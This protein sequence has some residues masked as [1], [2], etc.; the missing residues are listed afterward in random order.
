MSKKDDLISEVQKIISQYS[1]M[2]LTLRQIYYRLVTKL[3]IENKISNYKYLSKVL[4][5]ARRNGQIR[6]DSIEDRTR[7]VNTNQRYFSTAREH[8]EY[9]IDSL[10]ECNTYYTVPKLHLQKD[11]VIVV[12]EKQA[13]QAIFDPVCR[14]NEAYL[15]VCRG[16]NSLTQLKELA[17]ELKEE[18]KK[19]H[20]KF[21]SDFDPTGLDIQRNFRQQMNDFDIVFD[22]FKRIGLTQELIDK[23]NL[24]FAPVKTSDSRAS[25]WNALGVVELDALEPVDLQNLILNSILEHF[26]EDIYEENRRVYDKNAFELNEMFDKIREPLEIIKSKILGWD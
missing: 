9:H 1:G 16:Y 17:D 10:F 11:V 23:Y 22:S 2:K 8:L 4:V 26:D 14:K 18:N 21:F 7:E 15:I 12:L 13:L 25:N 5:D 20:V 6:F 24:P 19:L 3:I